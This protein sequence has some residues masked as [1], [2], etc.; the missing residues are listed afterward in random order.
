MQV[1]LGE[2]RRSPDETCCRALQ[3]FSTP[4]PTSVSAWTSHTLVLATAIDNSFGQR[5]HFRYGMLSRGF[6]FSMVVKR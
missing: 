4:S 3:L 6:P 1:P 5:S 2:A